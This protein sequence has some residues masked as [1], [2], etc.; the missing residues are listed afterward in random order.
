MVGGWANPSA[1]RH[2]YTCQNLALFKKLTPKTNPGPLRLFCTEQQ[3]K[4]NLT[5][6]PSCFRLVFRTQEVMTIGCCFLETESEEK[7]RKQKQ[8][9][10]TQQM[11]M[12]N[13]ILLNQYY[14]IWLI[15]VGCV[16]HLCFCL[17]SQIL[18][19]HVL[20]CIHSYGGNTGVQALCR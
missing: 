17:A 5:W 2:I 13:A 19:R 16:F 8:R 15:P 4:D 10:S 3:R 18:T 6:R 20:F 1:W 12:L 7:R 9:K 11:T 14:G